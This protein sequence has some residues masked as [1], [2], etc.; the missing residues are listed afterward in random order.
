VRAQQ[1][2]GDGGAEKAGDVADE[3]ARP[4]NQSA[5]YQSALEQL[6]DRTGPER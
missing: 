4:D 5:L 3:N 1:V 6:Q 2:G